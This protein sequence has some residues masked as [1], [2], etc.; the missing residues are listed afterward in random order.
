MQ[1]HEETAIAHNKDAGADGFLPAVG[2]SVR[3]IC[4]AKVPVCCCCSPCCGKP[5]VACC[6]FST[7]AIGYLIAA[8]LIY[9]LCHILAYGGSLREPPEGTIAAEQRLDLYHDG[10]FGG[11]HC[12]EFDF[13]SQRPGRR[14]KGLRCLHAGSNS[15]APRR[16]VI[17]FGGN[18]MYMWDSVIIGDDLVSSAS[19]GGLG[20]EVFSSSYPGYTPNDGWPSEDLLLDDAFG[21]V[22]FVHQQKNA[23]VGSPIVFGVSLGAAVALAVSSQQNLLSPSCLVLVNP[24]T[25]MRDMYKD[26][27]EGYLWPW[28][29]VCDRWPSQERAKSITAPTLLLSSSHD[30]IIPPSMHKTVFDNLL[31]A[32]NKT[33]VQAPGGHQNFAAFMAYRLNELSSF[34]NAH[35]GFT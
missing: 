31:A 26:I 12:L 24:F 27:T 10:G 2:R 3:A 7:L 34:F 8:L 13:D 32:K 17:S 23:T 29:W 11:H 21:L 28:S 9:L 5:T 15:S 19:G 14:I 6:L 20:L 18:M 25:S 16:Q 35:C 22:E 4:C 30:Q 33:F 1:D